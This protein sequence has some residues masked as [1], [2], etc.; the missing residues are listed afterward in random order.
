VE[1]SVNLH[2]LFHATEPA[3]VEAPAALQIMWLRGQPIY[4]ALGLDSPIWIVC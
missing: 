4:E 1:W 3:T 2:R